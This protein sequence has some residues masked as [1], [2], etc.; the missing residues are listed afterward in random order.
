MAVM[1]EST[2]V[3][4]FGQDASHASPCIVDVAGGAPTVADIGTPCTRVCPSAHIENNVLL[5]AIFD[6]I[7]YFCILLALVEMHV[8]ASAVIYF[9]E[10]EIPVDKV[11]FAVLVFMTRET[12]TGAPCVAIL[13]A[14]GVVTSIG[15]DTGFQSELV[16]IVHQ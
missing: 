4:I 3:E 7:R 14:A 9:D 15:V 11:E 2:H 1:T 12:H 16:N 8:V 13:I 10:V 6:G 5:A